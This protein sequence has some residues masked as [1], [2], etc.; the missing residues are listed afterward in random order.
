MSNCC[1]GIT[2]VIIENCI[3]GTSVEVDGYTFL[4]GNYV[5]NGVGSMSITFSESGINDIVKG[6]FSDCNHITVYNRC[7][8][9]SKNQIVFSGILVAQLKTPVRVNINQ[10][11]ND[12]VTWIAESD[13]SILYNKLIAYEEGTAEAFKSMPA[14]KAICQFVNENAGVG[15]TGD[16]GS[17]T[18]SYS[19]QSLTVCDSCLNGVGKADDWEGDRSYE[20]LGETIEKIGNAYGVD[21][22]VTYENCEYTFC[23]R[24]GIDRTY[25]DGVSPLLLSDKQEN[26]IVESYFSSIAEMAHI[27]IVHGDNE[28]VEVAVD[29]INAFPCHCS[30]EIYVDGTKQT[31]TESLETLGRE[32]LRE[33]GRI[34]ELKFTPD[35]CKIQF[36][37]EF[38]V[39][40]TFTAIYNG[41]SFNHK[42]TGYDFSVSSSGF[43]YD[44]ISYE[45]VN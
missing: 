19:C 7:S 39:G 26:I 11:T 41:Q 3:N 32:A 25:P 21:W 37:S 45:L 35:T 10:E 33:N 1:D 18:N 40:D 17:G 12:T 30:R 15:I 27:A 29:D 22:E 44:S 16:R 5:L 34:V 43:N 38:F 6:F 36:G 31:T 8:C 28:T 42:V 4:S 14:D 13:N 20:N 9:D 23:T 2:T 24:N